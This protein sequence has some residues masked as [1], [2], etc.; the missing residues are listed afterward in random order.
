MVMERSWNIKNVESSHFPTFSTKWR[1]CKIN[2]G[3]GPG[4]DMGKY[5]VK[6]VGTLM[7]CF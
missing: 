2:E 7:G 4:K 6:S 3:N 1:E 5:F